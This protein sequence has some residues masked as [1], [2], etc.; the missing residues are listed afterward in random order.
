M[1]TTPRTHR[2]YL[3]LIGV[4]LGLVVLLGAVGT[5]AYTMGLTGYAPLVAAYVPL[6]AVIAIMLTVRRGWGIV[7][8]RRVNLR[9]PA[10]ALALVLVSMLPIAAV[11]DSTGFS[12]SALATVG[13]AG[14][15]VLVGFVEETL[16]RGILP[17]VFASPEAVKTVVATSVAFAVAHSVT[18][19]SPD[20]SVGATAATVAFAFL[21]GVVASLLVRITGSIWPAIVLH[22]TFDFAGFVLTP[23]S[24]MVTDSISIA[25]A[26][27]VA[28]ALVL[29]CRRTRV[30]HAEQSEAQSTMAL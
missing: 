30:V 22:A 24:S 16:F 9:H 2:T 26:A 15:A 11:A 12:T 25:V 5:V 18:A 10:T 4:T 3:T 27:T 6:A 8:F 29:V 13:F 28:L 19:L 20:Q 14:M 23:R 1:T 21:F 7:G 17:R